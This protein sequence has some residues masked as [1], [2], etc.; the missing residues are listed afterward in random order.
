MVFAFCSEIPFWWKHH[1]LGHN[2]NFAEV[3]S[4]FQIGFLI[5]ILYEIVSTNSSCSEA[6]LRPIQW[7]MVS[8]VRKLCP[9][10]VSDTV[11]WKKYFKLISQLKRVLSE[12]FIIYM[13]F[14]TE[15]LQQLYIN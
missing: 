12:K 10:G 4:L 15:K 3:L 14:F 11:C 13:V 9:L 5:R 8:D 6:K 7:K 2:F 1:I